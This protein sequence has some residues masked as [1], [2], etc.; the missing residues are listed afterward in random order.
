MVVRTRHH[1]MG[2]Y[3]ANKRELNQEQS[4]PELMTAA[5]SDG[6]LTGFYGAC[7]CWVPASGV[8]RLSFSTT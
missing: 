8:G 6:M 2:N 7:S 3:C 5:I 4:S 1:L